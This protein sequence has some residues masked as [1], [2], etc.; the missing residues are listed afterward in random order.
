MRKLSKTKKKKTTTT[1]I[2][3]QKRRPKPV[4]KSDRDFDYSL[5]YK[6][7]NFRRTPDRYRVGKGEQGVLMVEPYKSE[8]LPYWRFRDPKEAR[9]SAK[10]LVAKFN[11]Y[12][13]DDDFVGMDMTRKF[14]QMGYT[15]AR[16]YANHKSGK[17]YGADG[18]MLPFTADP[19]KAKA[20]EIFYKVWQKIEKDPVYRKKKT[21]W[22]TRL[23]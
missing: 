20:A 12:K 15:R 21:D 19:I 6:K 3:E 7:L 4:A 13:N 23:G 11:E 5:D 22:K 18:K 8:I 1:A 9:G 16:R 17:K 2:R 14:I 10:E